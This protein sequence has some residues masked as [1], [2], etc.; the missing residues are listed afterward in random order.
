MQDVPSQSVVR[1]RDTLTGMARSL[2]VSVDR[3]YEHDQDVIGANPDLIHPGT[4]LGR[5]SGGAYSPG[6]GLDAGSGASFLGNF[7]AQEQGVNGARP[8]ATHTTND[9]GYG[10]GAAPGNG[11]IMAPPPGRQPV[12]PAPNVG[13]LGPVGPLPDQ[14]N[15]RR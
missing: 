13:D 15:G 7:A 9:N 3:L 2:G 14:G 12:A 4:T 8:T 6:N 1:E 11:R 5:P 10:A